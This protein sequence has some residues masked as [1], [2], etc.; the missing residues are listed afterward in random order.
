MAKKRNMKRE[1]SKMRQTV[2][3]KKEA[4][5][6]GKASR[7]GKAIRMAFKEFVPETGEKYIRNRLVS[8]LQQVFRNGMD[9]NGPSY[10]SVIELVGFP[11]NQKSYF[12]ERFRP[13]LKYRW[14]EKDVLEINI[15]E[16]NPNDGSACPRISAKAW[17]THVK[18][19]LSVASI[20]IEDFQIRDASSVQIDIPY[21]FKLLESKTIQLPLKT[22]DN[23]LVVI[24][25]RLIYY[26]PGKKDNLLENKMLRWMPMDIIEAVYVKDAN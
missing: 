7:M 20:T 22:L 5:F 17:T 16:I 26:S 2:K 3:T 4:G 1:R 13:T 10:Q 18:L 6:F 11:F 9:A 24:A 25:G 15:P 8:R 23:S 21:Q 19:I 12:L 14:E